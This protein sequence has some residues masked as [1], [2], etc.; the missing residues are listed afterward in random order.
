[1]STHFGSHKEA[2][3]VLYKWVCVCVAMLAL[4]MLQITFVESARAG[5][6]LSVQTYHAPTICI[7]PG[8][9]SM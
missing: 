4:S 9:F 1:M 8:F 6:L 2:Y 7:L 5:Q 3:R